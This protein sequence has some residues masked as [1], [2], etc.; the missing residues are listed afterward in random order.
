VALGLPQHV[1]IGDFVVGDAVRDRKG[2]GAGD[3]RRFLHGRTET[4]GNR[5]L[6][7]SQHIGQ[8]EAVADER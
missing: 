5:I 6:A 1:E 3:P 4:D 7:G 8:I 2:L